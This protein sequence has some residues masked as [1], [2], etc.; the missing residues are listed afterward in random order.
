MRKY[1]DPRFLLLAVA[2][3]AGGLAAWST[4]HYIAG[5]VA[6]I[7]AEGRVPMVTV[8]VAATDLMPGAKI[9]ADTVATRDMPREWA[10]DSAITPE[11]FVQIDAASL[12]H[13]VR[14]G[15]PILW[16]HLSAGRAAPFSSQLREGRRAITLAVDEISSVSGMLVPS[17]VIDVYVSFDHQRKRVTRLLLPAVH[18]LATG[19]QIVPAAAGEAERTFST[20]TLDTTPEEAVKLIVARQGGTISAVLRGAKDAQAKG[21]TQSGDL[22]AIFGIQ[23]APVRRPARVAVVYGDQAVK[24]MPSLASA[25]SAGDDEPGNIELPAVALPTYVPG[26]GTPML[27]MPLAGPDSMLAPGVGDAAPSISGGQLAASL[28]EQAAGQTDMLPL[29]PLAPRGTR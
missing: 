7:E 5:Q 13:A 21:P 8:V 29:N 16:S 26:T 27:S 23:P 4:R 25:G 14:R 15:E 19:R 17:D 9:S 3:C 6:R 12:G 28:I 20:V 24:Q 1:L 2:L 10:S 22:P 11:Q 18:V